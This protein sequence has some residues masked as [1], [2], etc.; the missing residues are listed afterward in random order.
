MIAA[1]VAKKEESLNSIRDVS[2]L[3]EGYFS[4]IPKVAAVASFFKAVDRTNEEMMRVTE[5]FGITPAVFG[6][7]ADRLRELEMLDMRENELV[8]FHGLRATDRLPITVRLLRYPIPP[9]QPH[10]KTCSPPI[11]EGP[12]ASER[13]A[14]ISRS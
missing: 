10:Y 3:Y 7:A 8:V 6:E 14:A 9:C 13:K 12:A 5:A 2:E 1:E 11:A 4:S